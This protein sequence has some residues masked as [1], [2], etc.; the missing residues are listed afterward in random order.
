MHP[1]VIIILK[2]III[3]SIFFVIASIGEK[4]IKKMGKSDV[5]DLEKKYK[6]YDRID[7]I[8]S[9]ISS[10]F[11]YFI[12]FISLLVIIPLYG[13]KKE[14]V[15]GIFIPIS[16][17]IGLS[18]QGPLSNIWYGLIMILGEL[19]EINDVITLKIQNVD[20]VIGRIIS[21][22]LF[23]TRL[24]DLN[25]GKEILVSNTLIYNASVSYNDSVIYKEEKD[26]KEKEKEEI[27]E[28]IIE[29]L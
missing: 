2:T 13:V 6:K 1:T 27:I 19:Y 8:Y 29:D 17:A 12:L 5:N 25:D 28:E 16:I 23:Y 14:T 10:I 3:F 24:V 11:F 15:Y 26:E 22:N 9:Q 7:I 4:I 18:A 21:I 20:Q